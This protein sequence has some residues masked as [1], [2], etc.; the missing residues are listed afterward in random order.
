MPLQG[1]QE[2]LTAEE[3][4]E[5]SERAQGHQ[6]RLVWRRKERGGGTWVLKPLPLSWGGER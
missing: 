6:V 1:D 3:E 4:E 5:P 2:G